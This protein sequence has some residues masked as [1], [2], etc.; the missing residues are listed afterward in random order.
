V[1]PAPVLTPHGRL[2]LAQEDDALAL[3]AEVA[4]RSWIHP[5][6]AGSR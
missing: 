2:S 1:L 3:H 4:D 5:A 6:A